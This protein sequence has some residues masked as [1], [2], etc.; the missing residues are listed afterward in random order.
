MRTLRGEISFEMPQSG[1]LCIVVIGDDDD[2]DDD[3]D[4][5]DALRE[6]PTTDSEE[7]IGASQPFVTQLKNRISI[8][9]YPQLVHDI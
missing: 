6:I 5:A 2:D 3:D 9:I 8:N 4:V 1:F 7:K